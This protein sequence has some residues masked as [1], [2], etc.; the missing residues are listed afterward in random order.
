MITDDPIRDAMERDAEFERWLKT[1]PVCTYCGEPIQ[2]E[3]AVC[4]DGEW[5][6]DECLEG[7][8]KDTNDE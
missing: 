8:R 4:I 3:S 1:R 6:C 2:E 5:I 7:M